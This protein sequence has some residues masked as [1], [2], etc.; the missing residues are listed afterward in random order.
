MKHF[1]TTSDWSREELDAILDVAGELKQNPINDSL[2]GRS[3]ALLF[4]NP[5][6]RTRCLTWKIGSES[7]R[8]HEIPGFRL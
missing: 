5:S 1:L 6:M 4:L 7:T 3:I 2:K 8:R